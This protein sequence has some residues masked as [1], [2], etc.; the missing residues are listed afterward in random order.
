MKAYFLRHGQS[1]YNV[2]GLCNADPAVPVGLTDQGREQAHTAAHELSSIAK[3]DLV[4]VSELLRA[5]E[6]ATIVNRFHS[7]PVRIDPRLNDRD[8][9][10]EGRPIQDYIDA[11]CADPDPL[12]FK[13]PPGE[14]YLD[15]KRRVLSFLE[16]TL[17]CLQVNTVL[18]VT[19]HEVLQIVNGY[20]KGLSDMEMFQ[21]RIGNGIILEFDIGD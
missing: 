8:T 10:F 16:E 15:Q 21:T 6:T 14:S 2:K 9:G 13:Q 12:N 19:H 5:Q 11:M 20:Y 3:L 4:F 1:V 18:V 17:Y 7:A